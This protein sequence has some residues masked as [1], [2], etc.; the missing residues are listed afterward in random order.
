MPSSGTAQE[1]KGEGSGATAA[2]RGRYPQSCR[3]A[4]NKCRQ[5]GSRSLSACVI[6]DF[7]GSI[8]LQR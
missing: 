7:Q 1:F 2:T 6:V 3:Q 4:V 8:L 5:A